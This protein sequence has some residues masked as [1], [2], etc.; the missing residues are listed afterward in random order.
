MTHDL[1]SLNAADRVTFVSALGHLFEHSPW[2]AEQ[3][4]A[5]RPFRNST[6]LH[7]ELCRT[8]RSA[9]P[10]RQLTLVRAHPD[11]A[12]RLAQQDQLT[13]A[14]KREQ[15]SAGLEQL[16]AGELAEFEKLNHAYRVRFAFPFVICA[17]LNDKAAIVDAMRTRLANS[18]E[19]ELETA[20]KEIEKIAQLRLRDIL[21]N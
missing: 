7:S 10:E 15:A 1:A 9:P 5:R 11:L 4:W 13:L 3:T 8:M 19:D 12:G 16:G 20:L 18:P 2:V 14:S 17:R 6:H 21:P